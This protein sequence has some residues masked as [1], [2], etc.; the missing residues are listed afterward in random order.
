MK[1]IKAVLTIA[2]L[3][4]TSLAQA[5][6]PAPRRGQAH[7]EVQFLKGMIDHHTMGVM[8]AELCDGRT[9]HADLAEMCVEIKTVQSEEIA[10]MQSWLHDWYGIN[11]EPHMK[12]S[13]ERQIQKLA[14]LTGERFEIKFMQMMSVHHA[15][16]LKDSVACLR[17]AHHTELIHLCMTMAE[18]QAAEI[19]TLTEWLC[20]WHDL[21]H[22]RNHH[23]GHGHRH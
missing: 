10:L 3:L 5:D 20:Q 16:A 23:H 22:R 12:P 15:Q 2:A 18:V 11:Y 21:C 17:K 13:D 7:Y 9:V 19:E 1:R 4:V 8:M 6:D 14:G